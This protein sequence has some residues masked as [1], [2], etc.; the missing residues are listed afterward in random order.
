MILN[1]ANLPRYGRVD[2]IRS[3]ATIAPP[4]GAKSRLLTP[5]DIRQGCEKLELTQKQ[6]ANL[7]GVGKATVSRWETEAQIQQRAMD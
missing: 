6:L 3:V 5:E 7:L 1:A 4:S 2:N